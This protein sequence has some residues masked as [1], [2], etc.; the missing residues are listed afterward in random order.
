MSTMRRTLAAVSLAIFAAAGFAVSVL[1][2]GDRATVTLR[3]TPIGRVLAGGNARTLYRF[4]GDAGKTSRCNGACA[5]SWPPLIATGKL[6]AGAGVKQSLL[7]TTRRKDGKLQVTYA[8]HP[9]YYFSYDAGAGQVKGE[10]VSAYGGR[11]YAVSASGAA[12]TV[13]SP[14]TTSTSPGYS[15]PMDTSTGYTP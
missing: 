7:G 10:G 12:V 13:S 1:A 6:T 5:V 15:V 2:S 4:M 9:L 11:W 8:G 3:V 14:A